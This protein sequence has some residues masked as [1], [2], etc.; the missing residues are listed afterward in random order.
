MVELEVPEALA[1]MVE[2]VDMEATAEMDMVEVEEEALEAE[3][4]G[5]G[6][7]AAVA[8]VLI[9]RQMVPA[10]DLHYLDMEAVEEEVGLE[11]RC[12]LLL[13]LLM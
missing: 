7:A 11:H 4:V 6:P 10:E 3:E 13:G 12:Q 5:A 8:E 9:P 1:V 2:M